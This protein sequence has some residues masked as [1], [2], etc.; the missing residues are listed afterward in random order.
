MK[1]HEMTKN[2]I[3]R[4]FECRLSVQKTAKLCFKSVR[5]IKD[6]GKGKE[7]PPECKRLMRKQ[8][9]LELSHH[10]EWK[11]FEMSWGKSQLPTGHRVTPQEILTG[12]ALIEIKSELEMRTCSKLIKFVRAIADLLWLCCVNRW[13]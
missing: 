5:T 8:S 3:F 9:R 10:E 7:I 6:W 13:N 11:G 2:Y 12:I 1:Y 4:E